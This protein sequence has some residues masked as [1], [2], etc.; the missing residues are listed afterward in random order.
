MHKHK[1]TVNLNK[2]EET[3]LKQQVSAHGASLRSNEARN[4]NKQWIYGKTTLVTTTLLRD[5][6]A[7]MSVIVQD[8]VFSS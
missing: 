5:L 4:N 1:F 7:C 3:S 2:Q 8:T 6:Q